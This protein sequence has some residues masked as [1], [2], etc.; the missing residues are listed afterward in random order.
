[1]PFLKEAEI[2]GSI[3]LE[4]AGIGND[5]SFIALGSKVVG[6]GTMAA[7]LKV[8]TIKDLVEVIAHGLSIAIGT[9]CH[10]G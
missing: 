3:V 4:L 2:F 7:L 6:I 8:D 9:A 5:L 10:R 1:M